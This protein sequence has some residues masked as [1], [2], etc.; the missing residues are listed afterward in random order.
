MASSCFNKKSHVLLLLP[1]QLAR[2]SCVR[3]CVEKRALLSS[4]F[5]SFAKVLSFPSKRLS[6]RDLSCELDLK[7][8]D[9]S[10]LL[11]L[12]GEGHF[13]SSRV[14]L[15]ARWQHISVSPSQLQG[16]IQ[17]LRVFLRLTLLSSESSQRTLDLF[18]T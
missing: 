6:V 2:F 4:I 7:V 14:F 16:A 9:L 8:L 13:L 18:G 3:K 17:V 5:L 1:S 11:I 15:N 12:L 10:A